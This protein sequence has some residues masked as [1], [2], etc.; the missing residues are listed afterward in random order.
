MGDP[1]RARGGAWGGGL[2]GVG[3]TETRALYPPRKNQGE[4][5]HNVR[6]PN[7]RVVRVGWYDHCWRTV[8]SPVGPKQAAAAGWQYV[9][10][11][12]LPETE[13]NY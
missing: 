9:G 6:L 1:C 3:V 7:G 11:D 13:L 10:L 5:W 12:T 2:V 4:F 8:K